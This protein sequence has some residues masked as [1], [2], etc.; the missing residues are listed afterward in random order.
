MEF[1]RGWKILSLE[2]IC[3]EERLKYHD[4]AKVEE[5]V[6]LIHKAGFVHGDVRGGNVLVRDDE[7]GVCV[8]IMIIDFDHC[9]INEREGQV[10]LRVEPSDSGGWL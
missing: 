1:L 10:P 4:K 7:N 3:F 8:K 2:P 5:A 9:G 6:R